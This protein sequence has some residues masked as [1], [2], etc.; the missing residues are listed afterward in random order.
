MEIKLISLMRILEVILS[1][2]IICIFLLASCV[3][4]PSIP[5]DNN[6]STLTPL[7][8]YP[9]GQEGNNYIAEITIITDSSIDLNQLQFEIPAL[10][11]NKSWLFMLTQDDCKHA[12]FSHTWAA[13]NGKPLSD[14]YYYNIR[15]LLAGDMPPDIYYLGKTLGVTDGTGNEERFSFTTTLAPEMNWM[16]SPT[17]INKGF[18][19][20]YFRFFMNSGLVWDNVIEMLNYGNG[21]AFHD[22][23][24]I[25]V[26]NQSEI[27]THYCISQDSIKK[28]LSNRGCKTLAEPNGNIN[29]Y[30]AALNYNPIQIMTG[31]NNAQERLFPFSVNTDL[32]KSFFKRYFFEPDIVKAEILAENQKPKEQREAIHIGVHGTGREWS[33]FLLWLNNNYGKDGDNSVWMPSLEEYYEYNYYRIHSVITKTIINGNTIKLSV[34]LP[35]DEYFYYPSITL[36]LKGITK[37]QIISIKTNDAIKGM[38]FGDYS[39]GLMLNIDCRKFL[40]QHATHYVERYEQNKTS[41]NRLDAIYFVNK[42]KDSQQKTNLLSRI[43]SR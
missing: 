2:L 27:Y 38:S 24:A 28:K 16:N 43:N 14:Q 10:K 13:I 39:E 3:E 42:L 1:H 22:V 33:E 35:S 20:N 30:Y 26:N 25:D 29:Y 9:Y 18:S 31:Q 7:Y 40:V 5:D 11:Y 4:K 12:A 6:N 8:L 37:S 15:H 23:S 34:Q 19:G 21:I 32:K 17:D 41:S 36:N